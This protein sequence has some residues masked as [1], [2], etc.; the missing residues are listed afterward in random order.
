M[1]RKVDEEFK[2]LTNARDRE[3]EAARKDVAASA[4]TL[5]CKSDL[6][7]NDLKKSSKLDHSF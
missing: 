5:I 3:L 7:R 4:V 6:R 2:K 1:R